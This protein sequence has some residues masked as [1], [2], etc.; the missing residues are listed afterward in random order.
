MIALTVSPAKGLHPPQPE[1][2]AKRG[3]Y[4]SDATAGTDFRRGWVS[5]VTQRHISLLQRHLAF[6][7]QLS[8]RVP[9]YSFVN[10]SLRGVTHSFYSLR[11]GKETPPC[12][13]G[14]CVIPRL[15]LVRQRR[16][17]VYFRFCCPVP[18]ALSPVGS[19]S[20]FSVQRYHKP[21]RWKGHASHLEESPPDW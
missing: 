12:R 15:K 11:A 2:Y 1:R 7:P 3:A 5:P 10:G 16:V 13:D 8:E 19:T 21:D 17:M 6:G 14:R 9:P 4:S 20:P 18:H